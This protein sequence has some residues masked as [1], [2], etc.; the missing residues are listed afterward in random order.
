MDKSA[1]GSAIGIAF[2]CWW[3]VAG[4]KGLPPH[5]QQI[6]STLSIAISV[7]LLIALFFPR[8]R[9]ATMIFRGHVYGIA[10]L[11][12]VLALMGAN[13]LL[14]RFHLLGFLLPA[15]GL[16]V[17]LHFIGL[18]RATDRTVFLAITAGMCA[19]SIIAVFIPATAGHGANPRQIVTGLG[20]ALVL[21]TS[22]L[23]RFF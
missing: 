6:G 11:F 14:N 21:W 17:G 16:I 2:G 23:T 15:V 19:I 5:W 7:A 10:V 12:E 3:G 18:W 1:I 8:P 9:P 4:S 20:C 22:T 13:A